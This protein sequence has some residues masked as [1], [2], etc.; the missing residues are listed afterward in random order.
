MAETTAT[1]SMPLFFSLA[2]FF[3]LIPPMATTGIETALQ[4]F[5]NVSKDTSLASCFVEVEKTAPTPK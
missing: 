1:P 2:I 4:M 3:I 5:C